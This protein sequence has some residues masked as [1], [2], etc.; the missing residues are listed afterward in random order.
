MKRAIVDRIKMAAQVLRSGT[1]TLDD[2]AAVDAFGGANHRL[3]WDW[4]Q[5]GGDIN[6]EIRGDLTRV[7]ARAR[8]LAKSNSYIK[9]FLNMVS[10]NV[11]GPTGFA[12]NAQIESA[13]G[14]L[15]TGINDKIEAAWEEWSTD[16]V[17]VDERHNL[18]S[19]SAL[20][21][22]GL[23]RD[24]EVFVRIW[25]GFAGNEYGTALE[26]IDPDMVD[27]TLNR[28]AGAEGNEIRMGIEVDGFGKAVAYHVW[29]EPASMTM[30]A[31]RKRRRLEADGKDG[32]IVHLFFPERVAQVR[33]YTS[34]YPAMLPARMLRKYTENELV[35]SGAA[36]G[37]MGFVKTA[38]DARPLQGIGKDNSQP[39]L[40]VAA[41]HG[42]ID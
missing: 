20:L 35:A 13:R 41:I 5:R 21:A 24:G 17:T 26:I 30:G 22:K 37:K 23:V 19:A 4:T 33:G 38:S 7:R 10:V 29:D 36:A 32:R 28:R 16:P 42:T 3:L 12:L 40:T 34:F 25:R 11:I 6:D 31:K 18:T 1:F 15:L 27:E 14:D 9:Q 39:Q 2:Q 8:D